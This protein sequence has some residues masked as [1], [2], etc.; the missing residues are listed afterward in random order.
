MTAAG[1]ILLFIAG[2]AI[3]DLQIPNGNLAVVPPSC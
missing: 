1:I 2:L 3:F